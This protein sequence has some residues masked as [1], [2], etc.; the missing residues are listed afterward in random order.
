MIATFEHACLVGASSSFRKERYILSSREGCAIPK[1]NSQPWKRLDDGPQLCS[2][3]LIA[4]LGRFHESKKDFGNAFAM[5]ARK[6]QKIYMGS[7][8][9][10]K[11]SKLHYFSVHN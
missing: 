4:T 2:K 10:P 9:T 6:Y 8:W 3:H 1:Q 5:G 7:K 11:R